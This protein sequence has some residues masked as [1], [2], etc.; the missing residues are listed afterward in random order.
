M[1]TRPERGLWE[2]YADPERADFEFWGRRTVGTSRRGFLKGAGLAA[3]EQFLRAGVPMARYMPAGLI[4]VPL[5]GAAQSLAL[6]GKSGLILLSDRPIGAEC[7]AHLLDDPITP[8]ERLFVRNNGLP[9]SV[10]RNEA[11]DW[12]VEIAGEACISPRTFS[13]RELQSEF[14]AR[15]YQL[16][17]ECAGNGRS[18]YFPPAP[19]MQWTT[20]AIGCPR[21]TGVRVRDVLERCGIAD[22][23]VYVAFEGADRHL[24]NPD[25]LPI[26]R[27]VP[28]HK[29][30]E[31][32]SLLAWTINGQPL[33]HLHGFPL[34]LVF[35]GWPG[36][37]SG[38][39]VRRILIRDRVHDGEKMLGQSYRVP[40][41]PVAPGDAVPDD[42]MCI[43]HTMPVKSLITFPMSGA[44]HP[45]GE[46]SPVRGHACLNTSRMIESPCQWGE[47]LDVRGHAWAGD[48]EVAEVRT[49]I[50]FGVTWQR[51]HLEPPANRLAWQRWSTR[52]S[53]PARGYYEIWARAIDAYGRSQPMIVPGWNPRGYLNNACHR[54]AVRAV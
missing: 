39:W 49:S 20:G 7:P 23:A 21:W 31:D 2:L 48:V 54:I 45:I 46:Q 29:A 8:V 5:A 36:S 26:S 52:I 19:G 16:Q 34:R 11:D 14:Q 12:T 38:K 3:M 41:E 24:S 27:G 15:T 1:T 25:S 47:P 22:S 44:E 10:G 18:R 17:L 35:G 33:P 30:L 28:M 6:P 51:T 50:D 32:E 37:A 43:I 53:F 40:C 13:S 4:P 9:P 42:N